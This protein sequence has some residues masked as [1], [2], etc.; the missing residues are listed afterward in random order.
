MH[1]MLLGWILSSHTSI[2][3]LNAARSMRVIFV[4]RQTKFF[5]APALSRSFFLF[6]SQMSI[7][8]VAALLVPC[9][10]YTLIA[11]MVSPVVIYVA[12]AVV[13][14]ALVASSG[15]I[16]YDR[17]DYEA[18]DARPKAHTFDAAEAQECAICLS[19]TS[20]PAALACGHAFHATCIARWL[21]LSAHATCP[22]CR[23]RT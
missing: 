1:T 6:L 2:S 10:T 9:A 17:E 21:A 15:D 3:A 12:T 19:H 18:I 5:F 4:L 14:V 11:L 20:S 23:A 16:Q 22:I 7:F 13:Y 8:A